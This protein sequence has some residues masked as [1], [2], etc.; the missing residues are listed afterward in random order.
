MKTPVM[1]GRPAIDSRTP[2]GRKALG[3][4]QYRT[5][6]LLALL[7]LDSAYPEGRPY[8]SKGEL[9]MLCVERG[10]KRPMI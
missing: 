4:L 5:R 9:C 7:G 3:F 2:Q 1:A 10:L 6:V 8:Y